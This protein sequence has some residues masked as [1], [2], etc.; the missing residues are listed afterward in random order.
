MEWAAWQCRAALSA[1]RVGQSSNPIL[2][3]PPTDL[4]WPWRC[5]LPPAVMR[6]SAGASLMTGT[7]VSHY[8][9]REKLGSGGMGVVYRADDLRLR[10]EVALKFLP[11]GLSR[12][13]EAVARFQR[14]ARAASAL[15]RPHI[16]TIYDV[17]EHEGRH[18]I[19][20]ELL[21][22]ELL[23]HRIRPDG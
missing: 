10:R 6:L 3:T 21:E 14:E 1:Y 7:A 19:A 23:A 15:N 8:Q 17:D 11:D 16:C 20:M 9:V 22:G 12:D 2:G 13:R 5:G 4:E 18:F